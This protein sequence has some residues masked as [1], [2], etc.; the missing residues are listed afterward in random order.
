MER[1]VKGDIIVVKFPFSDL[2]EVKKRPSIVIGV[3]DRNDYLIC[4]ITGNSFN[5][6]EEIA[7]NNKDI[8]IGKLRKN[9]FI[10]FTKISTIEHSLIEY[11]IGKINVQ[12][13]N[14][15]IDKI[16]NFIKL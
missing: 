6:N 11:K 3:L 10:R 1:F 12:L 9:S 4:Q 8:I 13:F 16:Y 14:E 15:V 7:L 2:S 5:A